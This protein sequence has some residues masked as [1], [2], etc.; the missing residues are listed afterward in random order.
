MKESK[1]VNLAIYK[2]TINIGASAGRRLAWYFV[3]VLF[4]KN[5]LNVL[6][7]LKVSLLRMFGA[8]IGKGVVVKPGVNIKFP[9]KLNIGDHS[10]IGEAV[11]IDNL[12][13]IVIGSNVVLSQ[14]CLL[15]SGSHD[16]RKET[17]DFLSAAIVL[18]DGVWICAKAVVLGGTT[19]RSHS[20]L[21]ANSVSPSNGDLESYTIYKGNP[22]IAI[23][24]R[25]IT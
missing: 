3:N 11:W 13:E 7:S 15:L 17:F 22:A 8:K 9:W 19:C 5:P 18:E 12:D 21:T 16:H 20:I 24:T 6:S 4:F 23:K 14:G 10:W 25:I 2:T 1:R